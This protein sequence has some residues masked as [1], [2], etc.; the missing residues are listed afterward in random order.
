VD[1]QHV[2][3]A[4]PRNFNHTGSQRLTGPVS[5]GDALGY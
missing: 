3:E 1:V 5:S 4:R 2:Q